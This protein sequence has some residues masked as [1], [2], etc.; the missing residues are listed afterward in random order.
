MRKVVCK[1]VLLLLI[2]TAVAKLFPKM[3]SNLYTT[4]ETLQLMNVDNNS[5]VNWFYGLKFDVPQFYL[6][7]KLHLLNHLCEMFHA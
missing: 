1:Y 6:M 3:K 2:R 5:Y 7:G 4:G